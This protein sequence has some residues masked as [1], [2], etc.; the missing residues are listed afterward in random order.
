VREDGPERV[1][2]ITNAMLDLPADH[3][4]LQTYLRLLLPSAWPI[5]PP[6][7]LA[8]SLNTADLEPSVLA[9]LNAALSPVGL[10]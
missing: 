1:A 10:R 2:L 4:A 6:A 5:K 9:L 7:T 8:A 3:P